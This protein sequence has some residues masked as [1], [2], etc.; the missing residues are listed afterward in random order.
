MVSFLT[1]QP[2]EARVFSFENESVAPFINFRGGISSMGSQAF[3]W[4]SATSYSGDDVDFIYGGE[5]GLYLRGGSFGL[6]LGVLVHTFDP[7]SGGTASNASGTT[8]YTADV[9]GMAYGPQVVFDFL[10]TK[11]EGYL[12][13]LLLGGGYQFAKIESTYNF[14]ATGQALVSGQSTLTE[15]YKQEAPFALLGISTEFM[16][17]GTTTINIT[18]GY[19]Y[20]LGDEWTYG[21]GGSN[22]AGSYSQG[23]KVNFEDGTSRPIDWSYAFIQLGFNFYVDLAR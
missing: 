17:S 3:R 1:V 4:Q 19:H 2:L 23:G 21:A 16:L 5:F 18:A 14:T 22:F 8:L 6:S 15:I 13:K 12:W 7:V 11:D 20:S 10:L 9:E